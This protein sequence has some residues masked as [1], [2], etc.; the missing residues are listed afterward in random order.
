LSLW[1]SCTSEKDRGS[2]ATWIVPHPWSFPLNPYNPK[3]Y[4]E[5]SWVLDRYCSGL[6][7][8]TWGGVSQRPHVLTDLLDNGSIL[9]F[10]WMD[11]TFFSHS[12]TGYELALQVQGEGVR[13]GV[14]EVPITL[15][16]II[17]YITGSSRSR[18]NPTFDYYPP[19]TYLL[20][21]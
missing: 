13:V 20:N 8:Q 9:L 17:M 4:G 10:E 7:Y 3:C 1:K 5:G 2:W 21:T 16:Y 15:A 11:T 14:P 6:F 12:L 18:E 19:T